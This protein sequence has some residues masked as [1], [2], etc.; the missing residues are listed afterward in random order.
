M[1]NFPSLRTPQGKHPLHTQ[2]AGNQDALGELLSGK[3]YFSGDT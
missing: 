3:R 2:H 1:N